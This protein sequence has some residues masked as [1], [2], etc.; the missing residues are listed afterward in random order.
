MPADT[1]VGPLLG[2]HSS[3]GSARAAMPYP[4]VWKLDYQPVGGEHQTSASIY[5]D[6]FDT[7][8]IWS[9]RW[10]FATE[11]NRNTV[12]AEYER[13]VTLDWTPPDSGSGAYTEV[14]SSGPWQEEY[15]STVPNTTGTYK[16]HFSLT[17]KEK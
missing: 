6:I 14:I 7:R 3:T 13:I 4:K 11:A 10:E 2:P 17:L 1:R 15:A 9:M 8:R 16:Y 12:K 5:K